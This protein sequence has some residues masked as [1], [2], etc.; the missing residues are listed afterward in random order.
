MVTITSTTDNIHRISPTATITVAF[1]HATEL[2]Y[3]TCVG[4][5]GG[6][7]NLNRK[8]EKEIIFLPIEEEKI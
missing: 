8:G 1:M 6:L 2:G 3:S 4:H 5:V 7:T